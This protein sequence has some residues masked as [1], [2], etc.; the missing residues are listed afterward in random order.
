ML[1]PLKL[2][3]LV[4]PKIYIIAKKSVIYN[5]TGPWIDKAF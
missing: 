1:K 4:N 3:F 2:I 5:E